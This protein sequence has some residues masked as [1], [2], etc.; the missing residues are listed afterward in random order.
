MQ[1]SDVLGDARAILN[2]PST[3][4]RFSDANLLA[5]LSIASKE[6]TRE[7]R[8]PDSRM[9]FSTVSG[10]QEYQLQEVLRIYRVYYAGEL[11]PR[12]DIPTLEGYQIQLYDNSAQGAGPA[13]GI[14]SGVPTLYYTSVAPQWSSAPITGT[15]AMD[16]GGSS[17]AQ[18]YSQ[19]WY[20]GRRPVYYI[21]GVGNLGIVPAPAGAV[22]V[23]IDCVRQPPQIVN[24]TQVLTL[25]D[26]T[27]EALMYKVLALAYQSDRGAEAQALRQNMMSSYADELQKVR[28][29]SET[30]SGTSRGINML[31]QRSAI[32]VRGQW[33]TPSGRS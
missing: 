3:S 26:I 15:P 24:I 13:G 16:G 7:L 19:S 14:L 21:R 17:F 6:L 27:R 25:P 10:V 32:G 20:P 2:E 29:W 1:A 33:K 5:Y 11:L 18:P 23:A 12:T 28:H 30:Y 31:T 8:V 4:G 22:P 9:W